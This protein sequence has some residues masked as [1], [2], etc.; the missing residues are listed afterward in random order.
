MKPEVE[1]WKESKEYKKLQEDIK[2]QDDDNDYRIDTDPKGFESYEKFLAD[3]IS[4]AL[5]FATLVAKYNPD[6][7]DLQAKLIP[8]LL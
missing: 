4:R 2:K 3:P 6:S 5:E 7:P 8:F 1:A